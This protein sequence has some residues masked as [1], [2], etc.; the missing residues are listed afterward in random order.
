M[1][2]RP[3]IL[4]AEDDA[5]QRDRLITPLLKNAGC[6]VICCGNGEDAL[7]TLKSL[8]DAAKHGIGKAPDLLLTDNNMPK[9]TGEKLI[10]SVRNLPVEILPPD[11]PIVMYADLTLVPE[12][13]P[14]V[15]AKGVKFV[16]KSPRTEMLIAAVAEGLQKV[17]KSLPGKGDGPKL[18]DL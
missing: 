10:D 3:L 18:P 5:F 6:D 7:K 12:V 1:P 4:Y 13:Q 11:F 8:L 2:D 15:E 9:M 14:R 17:G 16:P